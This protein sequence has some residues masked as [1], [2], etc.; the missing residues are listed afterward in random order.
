MLG[1]KCS[2]RVIRASDK[3]LEKHRSFKEIAEIKDFT[4]AF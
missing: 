1:E 3:I 2:S 4:V